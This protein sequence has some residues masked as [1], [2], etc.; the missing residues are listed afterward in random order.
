M[1]VKQ[2]GGGRQEAPGFVC[3]GDT[4]EVT[5]QAVEPLYLQ[6]AGSA[7][8][9]GGGVAGNGN[10]NGNGNGLSRVMFFDAAR[11]EGG[12]NCVMIGK[13]REVT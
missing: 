8:S 4:A 7:A 9:G 1:G 10:G 13:V 5:F 6:S 11:G 3:K 2:Q 12:A